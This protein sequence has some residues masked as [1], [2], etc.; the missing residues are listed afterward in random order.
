M[1]LGGST[2]IIARQPVL[3]G[4]FQVLEVLG[5]GG[6]SKVVR[7]IDRE[8]ENREVALKILVNHDA[9][10]GHSVA[11]FKEE[12]RICRSLQHPNLVAAYDQIE[13][14]GMLAFTMEFVKGKDLGS[15][16][17]KRK[18]STEESVQIC[19]QVL[20]ALAELHRHGIVHRDVKLENIILR[21]DGVAKLTDLG[22]M[23]SP[24]LQGLTR[25]GVLLGTAQYM[26]PEYV[27]HAIYDARGDVYALG[28][29][30][31]ELLT[32]RRRLIGKDG[33]DALEHLIKT[34]FQIARVT[35]AGIQRKFVPIIEQATAI[36]PLERYASAVEML[37]ALTEALKSDEKAV[38]VKTGVCIRTLSTRAPRR[39]PATVLRRRAGIV[40]MASIAALLAVA[41]VASS[42]RTE[43]VT[44]PTSKLVGTIVEADSKVSNQFIVQ[45]ATPG[46]EARK[47]HWSAGVCNGGDLRLAKRTLSCGKTEYQMQA[48]QVTEDRVD[49]V[50][51][52]GS[53]RFEFH[54]ILTPPKESRSPAMTPALQHKTRG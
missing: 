52:S 22:L 13:V 3:A 29:V 44:L 41:G 37:D 16:L 12:L 53:R 23:K 4:R 39:F 14:A 32:G 42:K 51:V 30:L 40:A 35:L 1:T 26:P 9:F 34:K 31:Y 11:R 33:S 18:F 45:Q 47:V 21:D 36:N 6:C 10:D 5:Q 19:R 38:E 27:Q 2:E 8:F 54:F 50:L 24:S 25:T 15:I 20:S 49:G 7:A 28:I 48:L 43:I 46:T 17:S